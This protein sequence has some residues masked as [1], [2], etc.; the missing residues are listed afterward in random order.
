[1][2]FGSERIIKLMKQKER[3]KGLQPQ[4]EKIIPTPLQKDILQHIGSQ[5]VITGSYAL[6]YYKPH[7][8]ARDIDIVTPYKKSVSYNIVNNLNVK[9]NNRFEVRKSYNAYR[10]WDKKK[11]G[12]VLDIASYPIH[13]NDYTVVNG[14][15]VA[16]PRYVIRG[17]IRRVRTQHI[18]RFW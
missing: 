9:Y 5:A 11:H 18:P 15:K 17:K 4:P 16:K 3:F 14:M 10:V 13:Q 7:Y 8:V 6:R 12:Y 2:M 1:M